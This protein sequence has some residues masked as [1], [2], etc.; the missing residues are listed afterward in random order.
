MLGEREEVSAAPPILLL[1]K[2]PEAFPS[3]SPLK[4]PKGQDSTNAGSGPRVGRTRS[5]P[6]RSSFS[7]RSPPGGFPAGG[8]AQRHGLKGSFCRGPEPAPAFLLPAPW[9]PHRSHPARQ[10][11]PG[12]G[13]ELPRSAAAGTRSLR[14]APCPRVRRGWSIRTVPAGWFPALQPPRPLRAWGRLR[15]TSALPHSTRPAEPSFP[16]GPHL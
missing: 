1:Q 3:S 14:P 8:R 13:K 9:Q 16:E 6:G 11:P 7:G 12:P 5:D 10:Q 15:A 2:P 4:D